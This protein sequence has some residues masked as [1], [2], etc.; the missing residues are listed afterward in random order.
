M[1]TWSDG[2]GHGRIHEELARLLAPGDRGG[3]ACSSPVPATPAQRHWSGPSGTTATVLTSGRAATGRGTDGERHP[4]LGCRARVG[5]AVLPGGVRLRGDRVR[6]DSR[7]AGRPNALG[8]RGRPPAPP[9]SPSRRSPGH[10]VPR[11]PSAGCRGTAG[12]FHLVVLGGG[13]RH[14]TLPGEHPFSPA[15]GPEVLRRGRGGCGRPA[16]GVT[17]PAVPSGAGPN[18]TSWRRCPS[19]EWFGARVPLPALPPPPRRPAALAALVWVAPRDWSAPQLRDTL[20]NAASP[21]P[22]GSPAWKSATALIHLPATSVPRHSASRPHAVISFS[23]VRARGRRQPLGTDCTSRL[24][25][26]LAKKHEQAPPLSRRR[27]IYLKDGG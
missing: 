20:T 21:C 4:A 17:A 6:H 27:W 16:P 26:A 14:A 24:T 1:P 12:G 18:R 10:G 5:G 25:P 22:A 19:P 3:D 15:D 8:G 9:S 13:L 11:A 2:E 23:A 7:S